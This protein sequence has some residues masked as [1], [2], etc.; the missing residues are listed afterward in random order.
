MGGR[1][2]ESSEGGG[3]GGGERGKAIMLFGYKIGLV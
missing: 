2:V 1:G 3:G